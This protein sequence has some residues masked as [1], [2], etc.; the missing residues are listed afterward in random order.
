MLFCLFTEKEDGTVSVSLR[1]SSNDHLLIYEGDAEDP[2]KLI[3][4]L[5]N[6]DYDKNENFANFTI[7]YTVLPYHGIASMRHITSCLR[8]PVRE[9]TGAICF[10]IFSCVR[11]IS[12]VL[13]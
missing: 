5:T 10:A 6:N 12:P 3:V 9:Y 1:S 4:D 2:N 13:F 11:N 7:T 8:I